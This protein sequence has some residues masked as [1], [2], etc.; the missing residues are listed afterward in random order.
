MFTLPNR[1]VEVKF[2]PRDRGIATGVSK[3]HVISGGMLDNS[4]KRYVAPLQRNG[5][6][7]NVLTSEEK[8][9][10]EKETG[11]NLSVYNEEFWISRSVP[12][13]KKEG[14]NILDLSDP[15][16][17]ISYKILL[18]NDKEI[19]KSWAERNNSLSYLFA[20]TDENQELDERKTKRDVLKEAMRKYFEI[21]HNREILFALA[22][23]MENN[24]R[25]SDDT[26][27]NFL[28]DIVE[29][30]MK[31]SPK[32]FLQLVNDPKL[33]TKA[34][35]LKAVNLGVVVVNNH[36]YE[37]AEGMRLCEQGDVATLETAAEF[38]LDINNREIHDL[39]EGKINS[40]LKSKRSK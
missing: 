19:A 17:Y 30:R 13:F 6:I 4:I 39:I 16:D 9:Y 10:L 8:E 32:T 7:K 3:N 18:A 1:K 14:S 38:L 11:L 28:Q 36:Q 21:E 31:E 24:K 29:E 12:L 34:M 27:I 5:N 23:I 35:I 25:L 37:T 15:K 33:I 26:S 22:R 2:I 40:K 20:I